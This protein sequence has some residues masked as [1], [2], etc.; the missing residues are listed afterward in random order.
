MITD[1][2]N[3]ADKVLVQYAL[4]YAQQNQRVVWADLARKMQRR[5]RVSKIPKTLETRLRTLKRAHGNDLSRFP[6]WFFKVTMARSHSTNYEKSRTTN[7]PVLDF[8]ATRVQAELERL[9]L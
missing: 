7:Y 2:T 1:F 9:A 6:P 4:K 3:E 8:Q 5:L